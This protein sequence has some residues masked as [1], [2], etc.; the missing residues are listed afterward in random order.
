MMYE[1][2][3]YWVVKLWGLPILALGITMLLLCEQ[4]ALV[5]TSAGFILVGLLGPVLMLPLTAEK[6]WVQRA[7]DI[8]SRRHA[9]AR[10]L[11][12]QDRVASAL[13]LES[14]GGLSLDAEP[15]PELDWLD[16]LADSP[17]VDA[18]SVRKKLAN[19]K[20]R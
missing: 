20:R 15:A 6:Y 5:I 3:R 12:A 10:V 8:E 4:P 13:Q 1:R 19:I 7:Q 16:R 9:R 18:D 17:L 2:F 14:D 11:D